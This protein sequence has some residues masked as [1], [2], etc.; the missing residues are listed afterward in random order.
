[1][2]SHITRNSIVCSTICS[3]AHHWKYS[4]SASLTA[5][6]GIHRW[7]LDSIHKGP[8][9][10]KVYWLSVV[11]DKYKCHLAAHMFDIVCCWNF[12][13]FHWWIWWFPFFFVSFIF[14]N[15]FMS[16]DQICHHYFNGKINLN[17]IKIVTGSVKLC[18]LYNTKFSYFFYI[19]VLF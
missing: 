10:R 17:L 3:G 15:G 11:T 16:Y 18:L 7:P 13:R 6:R 9:T 12:L 8:V 14:R 1:M 4:S 19:S 5:V 2:V